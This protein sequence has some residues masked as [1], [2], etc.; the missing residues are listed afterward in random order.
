[1]EKYIVYLKEQKV[2]VSSIDE[3][4]ALINSTR[5]KCDEQAIAR[6]SSI[7]TE[8]ITVPTNVSLSESYNIFFFK[9]LGETL[10]EH[11]ENY[12]AITEA[13]KKE[14]M[15]RKQ[16]A[17]RALETEK[18]GW[19]QLTI[20]FFLF[21]EHEGAPKRKCV[22]NSRVCAKSGIDAYNKMSVFLHERFDD[23]YTPC[24]PEATSKDVK[25]SLEN[26]Y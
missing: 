4:I 13:R 15:V 2:L 6:L 18:K 3:V 19:Y 25:I 17:L 12:N 11:T 1:M 5:L 26:Q 21:P 9:A 23:I 14:R 7:F 22:Y 20:Y 24:F 10:E 16:N 8:Q